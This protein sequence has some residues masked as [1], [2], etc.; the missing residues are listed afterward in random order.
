MCVVCACGPSCC[1]CGGCGSGVGVW[2]CGPLVV[3]YT[4]AVCAAAVVVP[5]WVARVVGWMPTL[6]SLGRWVLDWCWCALRLCYYVMLRLIYVPLCLAAL[7][8]VMCCD[9]LLRCCAA[10]FRCAMLHYAVPVRASVGSVCPGRGGGGA[11]RKG[12]GCV[13]PAARCSPCLH[14]HFSDVGGLFDP[15]PRPGQDLTVLRE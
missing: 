10:L 7:R 5:V 14:P 12:N 15:S 1:V 3:R 6:G 2:G 13:C 9:V 8:C 11:Q 4:R